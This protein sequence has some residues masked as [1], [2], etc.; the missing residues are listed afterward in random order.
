MKLNKVAQS[1]DVGSSINMLLGVPTIMKTNLYNKVLN[2]LWVPL[3]DD[4]L[5][6][7]VAHLADSL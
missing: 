2:E 1:I 4:Q 6:S 5:E 7:I 3:W